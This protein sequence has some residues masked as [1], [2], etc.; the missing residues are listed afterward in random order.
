[1]KREK[2]EVLGPLTMG[3]PPTALEAKAYLDHRVSQEENRIQLTEIL[4]LLLRNALL[5]KQ[6]LGSD[7]PFQL[8]AREGRIPLRLLGEERQEEEI[9]FWRELPSAFAR[10]GCQGGGG[11]RCG[12]CGTV[13]KSPHLGSS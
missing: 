10:L 2:Y 8:Q 5:C 12:R 6:K 11:R 13:R 3:E 4:C 7:S 9:P 1:M